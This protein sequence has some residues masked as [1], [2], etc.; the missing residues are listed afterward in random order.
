MV[1]CQRPRSRLW[2]LDYSIAPGCSAWPRRS[3]GWHHR[4]V[5]F[6]LAYQLTRC[7]L[8]FL[9]LLTRREASKEAELLVL[10]HENA[11][12]RRQAGRVRYQPADQAASSF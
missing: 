4:Y 8:D 9:M 6:S 1:A 11:V 7:L 12:L 10:R 3:A 2:G 5:I